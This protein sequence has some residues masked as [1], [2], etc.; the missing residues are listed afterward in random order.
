MALFPLC[1]LQGPI[2]VL[3][4]K[5]KRWCKAHGWQLP[6]A[7]QILVTLSFLTL[8]AG[9]FFFPP[10]EKDSRLAERVIRRVTENGRDVSA[11]LLAAV[12]R[13]TDGQFSRGDEL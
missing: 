11:A 9:V 3:E 1:A 6:Q 10:V 5:L 7:L 4:L 12:R 2:T 8:I 13:A